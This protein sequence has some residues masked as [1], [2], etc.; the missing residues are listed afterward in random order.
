MTM[1]FQEK[2]LWSFVLHFES[3]NPSDAELARSENDDLV[4]NPGDVW[5]I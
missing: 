2:R 5:R 1:A 3:Y 4:S